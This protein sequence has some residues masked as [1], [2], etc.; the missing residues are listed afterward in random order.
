MLFFVIH[1]IECKRSKIFEKP[2]PFRFWNLFDLFS[3]G[4]IIDPCALI[5]FWTILGPKMTPNKGKQPS[6]FG[7]DFALGA[8]LGPR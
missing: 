7:T 5:D 4:M 3:G 8:I 2:P 6:L 1:S